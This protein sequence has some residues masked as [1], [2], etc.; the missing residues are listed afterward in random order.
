MHVLSYL[1]YTCINTDVV[2][3]KKAVVSVLDEIKE[4]IDAIND[5]N[6]INRVLALLLQASASIKAASIPM[7]T[8]T[9]QFEKKDHFYPTQKNEIQLRFK[10]TTTNFTTFYI[11]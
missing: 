5:S 10:K 8:E 9:L 11:P 3:K 2:A 1:P 6:A 7:D 4:G